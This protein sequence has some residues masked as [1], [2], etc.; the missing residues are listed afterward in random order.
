M[1]NRDREKP[2]RNKFKLVLIS[3]LS[4]WFFSGLFND[5]TISTSGAFEINAEHALLLDHTTG[6]IIL[7]KNADKKMFPA[8]MSKLMTLYIAFKKLREETISLDTQMR[9]SEKAWRMGGSKMFVELDSTIAVSDLL[10]GIIVQSGNDACIV[11]A[12]GIA[13]SENQYVNLMNSAAKELGLKNTNFMNVTGWPHP[14]HVTTA[15]DLA[16]LGRKIIEDYPEFYPIFKETSYSYN[17]IK[18]GNRNPLLYKYKGADGLKT[19]HT[20]ASGYGLIASAAQNDRRLIIVVNG[21]SNVNNR[22]RE[23]EK[24]LDYGFREFSNYTLFQAGSNVD[25]IEVWLGDQP[26]VPVILS[27]NL[28]LI[29]SQEERRNLKVTIIAPGPISSPIMKG[30]VV[31]TLLVDIGTNRI[32]ERPLLAGKDIDRL[33]PFGRIGAA[34]NYLLWGE[35]SH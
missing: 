23:S 1:T 34:F 11:L 26:T 22:A 32:L 5:H 6:T 27:D 30:S 8:S 19:G 17:G 12:E 20:V 14:E 33:S 28:V 2:R 16:I 9:V 31:A 35:Q 3:A 24:I 15:R 4:L 7:E 18:Q 10:R 25:N 29:L 13:G 21:M